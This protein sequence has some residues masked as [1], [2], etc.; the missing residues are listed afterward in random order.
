MYYSFETRLYSGELKALKVL[1][2]LLSLLLSL[3]LPES[4]SLLIFHVPFFTFFFFPELP[5][6]DD[7]PDDLLDWTIYSSYSSSKS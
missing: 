4:K 2:F 1:Y 3:E 7:Y 6:A 5:D